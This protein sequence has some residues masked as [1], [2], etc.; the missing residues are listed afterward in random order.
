MRIK[1]ELSDQ[2]LS[3]LKVGAK[4]EG[5]TVNTLIVRSIRDALRKAE[6][7]LAR[8]RVRVP[9]IESTRPGSLYLDNAK[10]YELIDVP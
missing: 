10:I 5:I 1:V 3:K 9:V 2:L 4:T 8:R 6:T 7:T